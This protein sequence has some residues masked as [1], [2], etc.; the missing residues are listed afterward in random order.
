MM[1]IVAVR[2]KEAFA[3]FSFGANTKLPD[4]RF[5]KDGSDGTRTRDPRRDR[6][7]QTVSAGFA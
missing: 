7:A 4:K 1:R 3:P 6:C 5:L 2:P